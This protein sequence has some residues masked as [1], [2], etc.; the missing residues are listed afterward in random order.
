MYNCITTEIVNCSFT[1]N[2]AT[3][4]IQDS[5]YRGNA[6]GVAIG[7]HGVSPTNQTKPS[8]LVG[9]ST[10]KG[11]TAYPE[12]QVTSSALVQRRVFVGRGGGL[13]VYVEEDDPV[14]IKVIDCTFIN[15]SAATRGGGVFLFLDGKLSSHAFLLADSLLEGNSV[16]GTNGSDGS[17]SGGAGGG[18][19]TSL[20]TP[21]DKRFPNSVVITNCTFRHNQGRQLS[22]VAMTILAKAVIPSVSVLCYNL[23]WGWWR[24]G[25]LC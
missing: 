23:D 20:F 14:I 15:N 13:A 21:L 6:G 7:F 5:Q 19:A 24:R 17:G 12:N 8:V 22:S 18:I 10:F 4:F 16:I 1:D 25:C 2:H 3:S 9:G 11:N